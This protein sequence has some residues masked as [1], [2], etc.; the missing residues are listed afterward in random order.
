VELVEDEE[1][2][3]PVAVLDGKAH[4]RNG[5][6]E[7]VDADALD[8][9]LAAELLA[10]DALE[11]R[12]HDRRRDEETNDRVQG[13]GASRP[14]RDGARASAASQ[15]FDRVHPSPVSERGGPAAIGPWSNRLRDQLQ[16]P[17]EDA[18]ARSGRVTR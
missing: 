4:H 14:D 12:A 13:Q 3:V 6:G 10:H 9:D 17:L 5:Q 11:L 16:V 15:P 18:A 7:R 1:V 2:T 8:R